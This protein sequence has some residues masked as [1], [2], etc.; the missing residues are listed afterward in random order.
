MSLNLTYLTVDAA[1]SVFD[2]VMKNYHTSKTAWVNAPEFKDGV[3]THTTGWEGSAETRTV[4]EEEALA[5][6]KQKTDGA[7]TERLL[8]FTGQLE[9]IAKNGYKV[10]LI[11]HQGEDGAPFDSEGWLVAVV[12]GMPIYHIAPWDLNLKDVEELVT[13]IPPTESGNDLICWKGTDKRGEAM[14]LSAAV[15]GSGKNLLEIAQAFSNKD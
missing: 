3:F 11:Q 8:L 6:Y 2:A 5:I 14:A 15:T 10:A 12:E 4:T 9:A 1:S 7:Y 13:L